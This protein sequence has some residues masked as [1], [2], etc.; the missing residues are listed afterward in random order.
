[1]NGPA[2]SKNLASIPGISTVLGYD[3]D[4]IDIGGKT[5]TFTGVSDGICYL[6]KPAAVG[7]SSAWKRDL[8]TLSEANGEILKLEVGKQAWYYSRGVYNTFGITN[9]VQKVTLPAIP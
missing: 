2:D 7:F 9:L 4:S 5:V 1:M 3:G 8:T 6:I